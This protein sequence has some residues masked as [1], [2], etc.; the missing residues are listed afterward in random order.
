[1]DG[2]WP[3]VFVGSRR[4]RSARVERFGV[5]SCVSAVFSRGHVSQ[6]WERVLE[7]VRELACES[8]TSLI[9]SG[10]SGAESIVIGEGRVRTC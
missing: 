10:V 4:R 3:R 6:Q 5:T 9:L 8:G 2:E 1:V 7:R